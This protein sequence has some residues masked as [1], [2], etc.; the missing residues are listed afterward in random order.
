[1]K[2]TEE[3]KQARQQEREARRQERA[4][5]R[6]EKKKYISEAMRKAITEEATRIIKNEYNR[7]VNDAATARIQKQL[8]QTPEEV[9]K[10]VHEKTYAKF[11]TKQLLQIFGGWFTL[12]YLFSVKS[13]QGGV[14][15]ETD[16]YICS[17]DVSLMDANSRPKRNE[18]IYKQFGMEV[19]GY[20]IIAPSSAF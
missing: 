1:M 3:E 4:E 19:F 12:R 9:V 5:K 6:A 15:I 7:Y 20:A 2:L 16:Y 10:R 11:T 13:M 14:E 8:A 18:P 17:Q